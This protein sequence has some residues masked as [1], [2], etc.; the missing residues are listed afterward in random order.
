[1]CPHV[2]VRAD[3]KGTGEM[4]VDS[5]E[6]LEAVVGEAFHARMRLSD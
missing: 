3:E 5:Q 2:W 1:M 6:A 4:P